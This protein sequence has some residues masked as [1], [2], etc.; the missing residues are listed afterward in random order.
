M[1]NLGVLLDKFD[2]EIKR[3]YENFKNP[4]FNRHAGVLS[5]LDK[6]FDFASKNKGVVSLSEIHYIASLVNPTV[7]SRERIKQFAVEYAKKNN[8]SF[9]FPRLAPT[10]VQ[11]EYLELAIREYLKNLIARNEEAKMKGQFAKNHVVVDRELRFVNEILWNKLRMHNEKLG[12]NT[13]FEIFNKVNNSLGNLL[14]IFPD[15]RSASNFLGSA[16]NLSPGSKR[17]VRRTWGKQ[18]H[19]PGKGRYRRI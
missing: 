3:L 9:E 14:H 7:Y 18:Q 6:L 16:L 2:D 8:V 4:N 15:S 10:D 1:A 11:K 19:Y 5:L 13:A 17:V 12:P